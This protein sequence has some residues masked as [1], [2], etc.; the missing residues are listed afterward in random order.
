MLGGGLFIYSLVK[1][2][3]SLFNV[4]LWTN[5]RVMAKQGGWGCGEEKAGHLGRAML[6]RKE[7]ENKYGTAISRGP[8]N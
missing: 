6:E 5:L 7:G 1:E 2:I 4:L 3:F 8:L